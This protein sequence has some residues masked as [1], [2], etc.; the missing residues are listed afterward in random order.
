MPVWR[1]SGLLS[2]SGNFERETVPIVVVVGAAVVVVGAAVVVVV[3]GASL[4]VVVVVGSTV[5]AVV[6]GAAV[7][8]EVCSATAAG[9]RGE[10]PGADVEAE[11]G[12]C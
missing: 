11:V 3:V 2:S 8:V 7:V 10:P 1:P 4:R 9:V 6:T 12:V 5:V